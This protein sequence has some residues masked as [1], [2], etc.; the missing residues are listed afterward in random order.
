MK[1]S[2]ALKLPADMSN[3][4]IIQKAIIHLGRKTGYEKVDLDNLVNAVRELMKNSAVHA[5]PDHDGQIEI[6]FHSFE[7][8]IRIDVRDWGMPM[9]RKD[10]NTYI[11]QKSSGL[12]TIYRHVDHFSYKNLG[13]NGKQFSIIKHTARPVHLYCDTEVNRE[14]KVIEKENLLVITRDFRKGDETKIAR[15]IYQNYG[16]SYSK[17]AFY[18]PV[19]IL[20]GQNREFVSII[21]EIEGEVVG[22]FA[23][24]IRPTSNIAEIGIVV[25]DPDYKGMGIMNKMFD[26]LLIKAREIGL[27]AVFGEA[28][29][30]HIFSQKSNL[31]HQFCESALV[32]GHTPADYKIENNELTE[33]GRRGADLLAF[34]FFEQRRV[35]IHLPKCYGDQI[36]KSYKNCKRPYEIADISTKKSSSYAHLSYQYRPLSNIGVI[37]V[38]RYGKDFKYKFMLLLDQLR[39]KHCDMIYADINLE[40]VEHINRVVKFLNSRLFF[41]SGVLFLAYHD[42]DH[43]RLQYKHSI[44]I[45]RKNL[46]CYSKYCGS[47]LDYIRKDENR[48]KKSLK[49]I[50]LG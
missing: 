40:E 22:H 21:A 26:Y 12:G 34:H 19:R 32:L 23:L 18:Y 37:M 13:K 36:L 28:V 45:G 43:L 33:R 11:D 14:K 1:N 16:L 24:L 20:E 15:L 35:R 29:M 30:Y 31:T 17:E 9:S 46:V 5:Y 44:N 6:S 49:S 41:Y 27:S 8:G 50:K 39:S 7:H 10:F 38:H 47:L 42:Q 48:V 2:I 3:F 4:E 25:V